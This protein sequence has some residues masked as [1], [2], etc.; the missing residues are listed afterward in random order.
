MHIG[1]D[2]TTTTEASGLIWR[3]SRLALTHVGDSRP[4]RRQFL[5]TVD[6]RRPERLLHR[7]QQEQ[8]PLGYLYFEDLSGGGV[9]PR[10]F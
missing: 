3:R 10:T 9:L 8:S 4:E 5:N 2:I 7:P 6:S 1:V